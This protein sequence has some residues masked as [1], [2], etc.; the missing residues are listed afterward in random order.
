MQYWELKEQ[1]R[2]IH[3]LFSTSAATTR[4]LQWNCVSAFNTN[5]PIISICPARNV[6]IAGSELNGQPP[7]HLVLA[8]ASGDLICLNRDSMK[9]VCALFYSNF[10]MND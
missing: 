7:Y 3:S 2:P 1:E 8:T 4:F 9:Q 6:W 5:S 10:V